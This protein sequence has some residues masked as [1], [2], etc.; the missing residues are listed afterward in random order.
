MSTT[1]PPRRTHTWIAGCI[2]AAYHDRAA[3]HPLDRTRVHLAMVLGAAIGDRVQI[4]GDPDAALRGVV[5]D[6]GRWADGIGA[7]GPSLRTD[8]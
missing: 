8:G 6:E 3:S 7:H 4:A 2:P 5:G 1:R